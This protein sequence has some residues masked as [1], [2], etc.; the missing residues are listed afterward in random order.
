MLTQAGQQEKHSDDRDFSSREY[1]EQRARLFNSAKVAP[2]DGIDCEI[3]GNKLL[4]QH[5]VEYNGRFYEECER[6]ACTVKRA[7]MARL[8]K[9]G[10]EDAIEETG[11]FEVKA[12]W[13]RIVKSKAD[14]FINQSEA[15]CFFIGG[16]SG[17][18][19]T[20]I[21]TL[22]SKQLM[23]KGKTLLYHKWLELIKKLNDFDN[24]ERHSL[25]EQV[26]GVQVLYLDD[27][28]KPRGGTDF[29]RAEIGTTFELIDRRYVNK[30]CITIISS[31]L[32]SER[33]A[34]LDIATWRRIDEM[35]CKEYVTNIAN[36]TSK[37]FRKIDWGH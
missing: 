6:C 29:T 21:S 35:A 26:C 12:E 28:F 30:N 33:I 13:Q 19:K 1:F 8:K 36:D 3:C 4:I 20:H 27:M 14:K 15:R 31:E 25:F 9:S 5:V 16:Q 34:Q 24:D 17:S 11:E 37:I 2:K 18:G 22:I 10:L 32:T 23:E 7:E